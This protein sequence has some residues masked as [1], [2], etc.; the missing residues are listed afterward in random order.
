MPFSPLVPPF[1]FVRQMKE[2]YALKGFRPTNA[3]GPSSMLSRIM[4]PERASVAPEVASSW[5]TV[6]MKSPLTCSPRKMAADSSPPG[7]PLSVCL[8]VAES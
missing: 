4:M 3:I 6:R 1:E 2:E 8:F 5:S 7:C